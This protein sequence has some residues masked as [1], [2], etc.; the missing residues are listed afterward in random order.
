MKSSTKDQA[1]PSL[2]QYL[3]KDVLR[4]IIKRYTTQFVPSFLD[5]ICDFIYA[6]EPARSNTVLFQKHIAAVFMISAIA[7]CLRYK[8]TPDLVSLSASER[9]NKLNDPA[10]LNN[11]HTILVSYIFRQT[12]RVVSGLPIDFIIALSGE[13][14]ESAS[15]KDLC[16]ALIPNPDICNDSDSGCIVFEKENQI[17]LEF[18]EVH[19]I[20][21]QLNLAQKG[22][23]AVFFDSASR[24]FYTAGII[25]EEKVSAYPRFVFHGHMKWS[26]C[27]E[28]VPKKHSDSDIPQTGE[29]PSVPQTVQ[30]SSESQTGDTTDCRLQFQHGIPLLPILHLKDEISQIV[31]KHFSSPFNDV[32]SEIIIAASSLETGSILI[33]ADKSVIEKETKVLTRSNRRGFPLK[34]PCRLPG[35]DNRVLKQLLNIDGALLIDKS[36]FCHA[37]GVILDGAVGRSQ[38]ANP[39]PYADSGRG[40]RYNSTVLYVHSLS[41]RHR[42][43]PIKVIGVVRSE[44][45]MLD[46]IP[47]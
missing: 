36:G 14:Y 24:K 13:A 33:F 46:F 8:I 29:N 32:I 4:K 38:N 23:L 6:P 45:G 41:R 27:I 5:E 17:P 1:P 26:F 39:L 18:E 44:D 15:A 9:Q 28:S 7:S 21:K 11:L 43:K 12:E 31:S 10:F 20:R 37:Y 35:N 22:A 19:A 34:T 47:P 42:T 40:S 30:D 3:P 2:S 25:A 16:L